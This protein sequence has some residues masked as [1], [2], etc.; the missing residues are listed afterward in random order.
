MI[1]ITISP[2]QLAGAPA[3]VRHWIEKEMA[4]TLGVIARA[5]HDPSELE[6]SGIAACSIEEVA[7]IFE[8][9]KGNY[10]ACD[11]FFELGRDLGGTPA[12]QPLHAI[13]VGDILRHT[14]LDNSTR[15]LAC[16]EAINAAFHNVRPDGQ[17]TMLGFDQ[18]GHIYLHVVTH[19]N[20]RALWEHLTS[21]QAN[22]A[23]AREAAGRDTAPL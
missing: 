14:R 7:R 9:L 15:L 5:S 20:I 12:G 2:E 18:A 19:Q 6:G 10:L 22:A 17:A 1:G 11:V 8:L 3:E 16:F 23:P 13:R 4:A 21:D